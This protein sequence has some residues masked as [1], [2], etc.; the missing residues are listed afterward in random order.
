MGKNAA[1][2]SLPLGV[3]GSSSTIASRPGSWA[4]AAHAGQPL[5]NYLLAELRRVVEL[6]TEG[7]FVARPL[8]REGAKLRMSP[9]A[10][11]RAE[12]DTR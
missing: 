12:R 7:E 3:G 10:A 11:V 2:R 1:S 8:R 5:T 9:A 4:C 6:P